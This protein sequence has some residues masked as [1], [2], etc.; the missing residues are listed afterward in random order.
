MGRGVIPI[1][2]SGLGL[3]AKRG[4]IRVGN[5]VIQPP[6]PLSFGKKHAGPL[7]RLDPDRKPEIL[8]EG[9]ESLGENLK[10]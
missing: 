7:D 9:I 3:L 2:L 1:I 10:F 5:M 6:C 8:Y 4:I